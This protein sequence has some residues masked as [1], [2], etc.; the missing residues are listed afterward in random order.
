M[1]LPDIEHN[2]ATVN[3][4]NEDVSNLI[5]QLYSVLEIELPPRNKEELSPSVGHNRLIRLNDTITQAGTQNEYQI[6]LLQVLVTVLE[7][8]Q[9]KD[10]TVGGCEQHYEEV[11]YA[12]PYARGGKEHY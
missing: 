1:P 7:G 5:H 10:S 11:G 12:H 2:I 4:S 6:M 3:R 9:T 8:H